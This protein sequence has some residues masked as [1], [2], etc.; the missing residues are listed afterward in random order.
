MNILSIDTVLNKTYIA[1]LL[2]GK[3]I[4]KTLESDE[5]CYHSAYLIKALDDILKENNSDL[6]NINYIGANTGVGS[7]TG[8]RVGLSIA[9][10]IS[11]RLNINAVPFETFEV[12]SKAYKNKNIML[13]ARRSSVFY[14]NNGLN[15]E[16][17]SYEKAEEILKSGEKFICDNSLLKKFDKYKENFTSY[18]EKEIDLAEF[19]LEIVTE[20]IK[21]N[22]ITDFAG[23]KPTYIQTPPIFSKN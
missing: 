17:I 8:I 23:I 7:F 10:I 13:D 9:K 3:K 1:L 21:N 16:L 5:K 19:E 6:K 14:S 4:F 2:N 22:Q 15:I 20:K 12:L 11:N 18:E